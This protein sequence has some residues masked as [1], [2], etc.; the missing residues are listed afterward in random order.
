MTI[1]LPLS[2]FSAKIL[3]TEYAGADPIAPGRADWLSDIIRIDRSRTQF[4]ADDEAVVQSAVQI[5]VPDWLAQHIERQGLRIG[6]VV[7][8]LHLENLS[9]HMAAC[10]MRYPGKGLAMAALRDFYAHYGLSDDDFSQESAYRE[11]SRFSKKFLAKG[12]TNNSRRVLPQSRIWQH[13][14]PTVERIN[15]AELDALCQELD[16]RLARVRIR[17]VTVLSRHAHMY[18]YAVRG[19]RDIASICRRFKKHRAAVYRALAHIRERM[20]RDRKFAR[21]LKPLLDPAFV[22]PTPLERADIC[23]DKGRG[24]APPP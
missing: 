13:P 22:L 5:N 21:A 7:H 3:S 1:L 2:T 23:T 15:H 6:V 24:L 4:T 19:G 10:A 20:K 18:I 11:Y 12:A 14:D 8:R 9:R 16:E 17:R